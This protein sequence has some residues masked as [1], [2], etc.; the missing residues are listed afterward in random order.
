MIYFI[1]CKGLHMGKK[2]I[3]ADDLI[4]VMEMTKKLE[5]YI[6][7]V[8]NGN[9][10]DLAVSALMSAFINCMLGQCKNFDQVLFYR[11]IFMQIYDEAIL[12]IKIKES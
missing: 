3:P 1:K 12:S 11:H 2:D 10:T 7:K 5:A 9:Q 4:D 6:S 8:L